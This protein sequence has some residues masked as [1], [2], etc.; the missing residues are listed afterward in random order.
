MA[1]SCGGG[2]GVPE[3]PEVETTRRGISPLLEGR[4]VSTVNIRNPNLRQPI[5]IGLPQRLAGQKLQIVERRAKYLLFRFEVGTLIVH[6]GMSG[7][8]RVTEPMTSFR[9]H[10]HVEIVF[11]S[12]FCLRLHDPRRFGLVL[13]TEEPPQR[14]PLLRYLGPEPWDERFNGDYLHTSARRRRAAVKNFIM[15]NRIVVGVGNIYASEALHRAKVHPNRAAGRISNL[16]YNAI[17]LS[18]REVL[19]EAVDLGGTTLRDFVQSDGEP[20]YFRV[21]LRVYGRKGEPCACANGV[22]RQVVIGQRSSFY[23]PHCQRY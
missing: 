1:F 3:L 5:Q 21:Q 23:C 12:A 2:D 20:G 17:V 13:W 10:D 16:R 18:V 15:N 11:D 8:L 22:I 4:R 7:S 19:K 6:L 14:H 9:K